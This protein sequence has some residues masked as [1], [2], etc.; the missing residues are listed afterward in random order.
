MQ[1]QCLEDFRR[2]S[3]QVEIRGDFSR[4]VNRPELKL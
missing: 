2:V 1:T 3:G 4:S